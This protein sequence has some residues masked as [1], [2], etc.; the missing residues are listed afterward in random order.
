MDRAQHLAAV[1]VANAGAKAEIASMAK[2]VGWLGTREG[3]LAHKFFEGSGGMVAATCAGKTWE[4]V[5]DKDD[6]KWCVP[7]P[8][9]FFGGN[10]QQYGWKLP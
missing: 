9:P 2:S 7:K 1:E 8:K 5:T 10:D 4:V 6:V 3:R